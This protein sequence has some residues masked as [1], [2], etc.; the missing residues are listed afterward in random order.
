MTSELKPT[1]RSRLRRPRAARRR[2]A[3]GR[4]ARAS[5]ALLD[6]GELRVATPGRARRV[7]DA[8]LGQAGHPALLR[9]SRKMERIEVGPFE[10]HDK[11]PLKKDLDEA[12]RARRAA[13][14]RALRRVPRAGR[15]RDARLRQ[16]RRVR[17]RGHDGRHLGHRRLAARRSAATATSP[18]ASASAACS[19]RRAR[20]RSSSRTAASSARA[21]SSSRACCVEREAVIGAGVVLTAST[22]ILDVTGPERRSSTAAA[23]RRAASSS[24]ARARRSS[25]PASSACRARSS[26]ASAARAPTAR[27]SLNAA[28]RDFGVPVVSR[29]ARAHAIALAETLLWLCSIP[30]PIGEE[31][32]L[33][34]ARR[35]ARSR[36]VPLAAPIRRYGD[37]IVVPRRRAA[38]AARTSRS[39]ATS[40]SVRTEHDGAAAHRGRQLLRRRAPPT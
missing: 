21:R 17:R 5:I 38:R 20:G 10:F 25:P 1:D 6:R 28:L 14:R 40:T 24:R 12:G 8:R 2:R 16:H 32:A 31:Q 29:N 3:Q 11:I 35:R 34:D 37:S 4:R 7:D 9:A 23:S 22:A 30:S 36:Q 19:S 15:H 33:C 18:A 39:P 27:V 13:G 26:S